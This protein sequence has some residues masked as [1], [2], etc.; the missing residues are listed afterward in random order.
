[1]TVK[2]RSDLLALVRA[3]ARVAKAETDERAAA[4]LA[5]YERQSATIFPFDRDET[6]K[7]ATLVLEAAYRESQCQVAERCDELGIPKEFQPSLSPPYWRGRG[8]NAFASRR[9][10]LRKVAMTQIELL[11][12]TAVT[13]IERKAVEVQEQL[14]ADGLTSDAARAF[15]EAMPKVTTLMPTLDAKKLLGKLS[16]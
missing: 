4:L 13:L 6:W 7:A 10:E 9:A 12:K 11:R 5:D 15:L 3:R 8:E 16:R 2:E 1:M 14:V